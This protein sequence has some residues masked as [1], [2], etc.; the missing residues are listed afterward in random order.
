MSDLRS[1]IEKVRQEFP[2]DV[3]TISKEVDPRF[4]ITAL[5]AKLEQE[6]RF[7]ILIFENVKGTK[8]PVV[9]NVHASRRRLATA[10][11]SE[12]RTAVAGYLKRI[13]RPLPPREVGTGPVKEMIFKDDQVDLR[14]L[15]QIVHHEGDAGP[16][17]T[18]AV[19]MARDPLSGRLNCSFNRLMF[20]DKNRTSIHLTLAKH[21]WEFYTNAEKMKQPL[22]VAVILGCP[23]RLVAGSAQYRLNRRRG[24]LP[25]G[26]LWQARRWKWCLQRLSISRF[27]PEQR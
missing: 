17:L 21:L 5:V 19:T 24:V 16:Y 2:E 8:F 10:I 12:P 13:Q 9:T 4:E 27:R 25:H 15:P 22:Q 6:R 18:A 1:F 7:P 20:L 26:S 3:L 14:G 23:S 11:G